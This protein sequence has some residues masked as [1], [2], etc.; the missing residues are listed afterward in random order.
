V[1]T[2]IKN[3]TE[4]IWALIVLLSVM[5]VT[6][7]LLRLEVLDIDQLKELAAY[8]AELLTRDAGKE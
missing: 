3:C 7:V 8:F 6:L 5:L 1:K 4:L 2:L